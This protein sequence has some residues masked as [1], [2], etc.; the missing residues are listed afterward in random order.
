M[1]TT[2]RERIIEAGS[3]LFRRQGYAGTGMKAIAAAANAPFGS[4]YHFFPGGKDEL[5]AAVI[6][7]A[8]K[9]YAAL[10]PMLFD[11]EPDVA[12]ATRNSFRGA[13]QTLR[14]GDY[15]DACPIAAVALEVASTNEPLRLVTAE[16][17]AD[18]VAALAARYEGAGIA[19]PLARRLATSVISMLEGAFILARA[20]RDA[21]A[22]EDA[23]EIM[24][25]A[26]RGALND[27][28]NKEEPCA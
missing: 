7:A 13:A 2:T 10:V 24:F 6:R 26:V 3:A 14:D 25:A 5:S 21:R 1:G 22:V 4:I 12:I 17:F 23:G 11:G 27:L 19:A 16:V 9:F 20:S 8:G 28:A 15:A 18:W